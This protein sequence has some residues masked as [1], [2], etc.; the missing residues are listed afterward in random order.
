MNV[1]LGG[2]ISGLIYAFYHPDHFILTDKVGGQMVSCFDLGPRYLHNKSNL[3]LKFLSDLD[4]PIKSST[5][6][7]GYI[8]DSGWIENP[9]LKYRQEYFMKS[10]CQKSL[11]GFDSSVL[12]TNLKEFEV[13]KVDFKE[14]VL[15]LYERLEKRIFIGNIERIDLN[16]KYVI[17]DWGLNLKY[18][19]L[20]STIPLNIFASVA[21]LNLDV[22]LES[23]DMA[24]CLLSK[25]FFD[26]KEFDFVY[27]TMKNT[28]FHRM[29]SCKQ[30]IVCDVFGSKIEDFKKEIPKEFFIMPIEQS[31]KLIKNSQIISLKKDF[32]LQDKSVKFIGRYSTW[33]RR[34]KTETV[35]E[36]AQK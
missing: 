27:N 9:D 33:N 21:N 32:E 23:F 28:S 22:K 36:E 14:L 34:W 11:D 6:K 15:K 12:N 24:Y 26:L 7:V 2:G 17:T 30:G 13:C 18:T 10:R 25:S 8:S 35:I 5:I 3:I 20:V 19:N 1:I 29:S 31:I 4:I 16:K